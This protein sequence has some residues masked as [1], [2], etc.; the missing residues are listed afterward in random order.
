M[1]TRTRQHRTACILR[2]WRDKGF[3]NFIALFPEIPSDSSWYPCLSYEEVG[4][5]G[6]ADYDLVVQLTTPANP[7]DCPSLVM[8]LGRIGYVLKFYQRQTRAM[9]EIRQNAGS[10]K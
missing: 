6:G 1:T 8:E 7:E 2:R 10:A 9:V 4:Q 5:H 3:S